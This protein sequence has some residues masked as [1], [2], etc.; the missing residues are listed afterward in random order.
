MILV[1]C[2]GLPIH[3]LTHGRALSFYRPMNDAICDPAVRAKTIRTM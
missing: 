3:S 2:A 1:I